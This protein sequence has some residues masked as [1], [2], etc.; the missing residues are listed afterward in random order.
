MIS[1]HIA[2]CGDLLDMSLV[3]PYSDFLPDTVRVELV[4]KVC[5]S[6]KNFSLGLPRNNYCNSIVSQ[7]ESTHLCNVHI[8]HVSQV[9]TKAIQ[10]VYFPIPLAA[11]IKV[12]Q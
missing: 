3:L 6:F 4:F 1:A 7:K 11:L 10:I 5:M 8:G 9:T 2:F 12:I